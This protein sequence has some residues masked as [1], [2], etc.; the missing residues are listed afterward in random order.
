M[1]QVMDLVFWFLFCFE[2]IQ[3]GFAIQFV[4]QKGARGPFL[5]PCPGCRR[6]GVV[7]TA[8]WGGRPRA[9]SDTETYVPSGGPTPRD[10]ARLPTSS[11]YLLILNPPTLYFL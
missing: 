10:V 8:S 7:L 11:H 5:F 3:R 1:S 2:V 6:R 9:A 4:K